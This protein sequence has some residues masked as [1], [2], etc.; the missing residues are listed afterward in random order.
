[1]TYVKCEFIVSWL[2]DE[3]G[4]PGEEV[5]CNRV[6]THMTEDGVLCCTTCAWRMREER[7]TVTKLVQKPEA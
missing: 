7:F 6:A 2:V 1:M 5:Y 4:D 3:H